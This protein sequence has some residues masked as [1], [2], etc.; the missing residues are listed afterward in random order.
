M[1]SDTDDR[2]SS[3]VARLLDEYGLEEFG[4]ELERRWTGD[5]YERM[6][7]R[8]LADYFNK[9]LLEQALRDAGQAALDSDVETTY[10][11]LTDDDVSTG[12]RTDTRTR[13][14]REG[15]DVESLERDFVT[16]QAIRSYLK[17]WRGAEYQQ[18]SDE[19]K[20]ANDRESIQRLLTR[21]L[22]VTEDRIEKLRDTDRI[23]VEE[24]EVFVDAQVLCQRCGTQYAVTEFIDN[25][26]CDCLRD[27]E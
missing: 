20:R 13:L 11:N 23:D 6:S 25:G 22:S 10:R 21:T 3:K 19:E 27:D 15:L 16:Y 2:P 8:D 26:G 1:S 14:E 18:P 24:F 9:R 4:R 12:V 7:L 17:E 5:G